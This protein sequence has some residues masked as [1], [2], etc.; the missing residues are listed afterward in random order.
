MN[1]EEDRI[2]KSLNITPIQNG[3]V[4]ESLHKDSHDDSAKKDFELARSN[5]LELIDEGK[6]SFAQLAQ[7]AEK[8]QH[9]RHYEVLAK[10]LDTLVQ[11]NKTVLSLQADVR[12]L[13]DP[14]AP[15]NHQYGGPRTLNQTAIFV[16]TPAALQNVISG[17]LKTIES[18]AQQPIDIIDIESEEKKDEDG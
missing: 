2:G 9:P 15:V 4:V 11:A 10:L 13:S 8:S 1:E 12:N 16:G 6:M 18:S 14:G 17:A 5:I 3:S 7:V